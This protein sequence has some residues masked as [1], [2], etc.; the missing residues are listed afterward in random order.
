[1]GNFFGKKSLS[2]AQGAKVRTKADGFFICTTH[3]MNDPDHPQDF[4]LIN[5]D[6]EG[7][8]VWAKNYGGDSDE[9]CYDCDVTEDGGVILGGHTRLSFFWS[10]KLGLSPHE[11]R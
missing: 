1:M 8:E 11:N 9:H 5:L 6:N 4:Y 10:S 3:W 7:N 2:T